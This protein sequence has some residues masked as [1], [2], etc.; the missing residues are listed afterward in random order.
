MRVELQEPEGLALL[1][2]DVASDE[3]GSFARIFCRDDLEAAGLDFLPVQANLSRNPVRHTLRGLHFQAPPHG[4][5]KIVACL[6]GAIWDVAVDL[7]P[8]SP[9]FGQWRGFELAAGG[10]AALHIPAGFAQGFITLAP[11]SELLYLMGAPYRPA[12]GF[13]IRWDDPRL[14]IAWP[15]APAVMSAR[16]AALPGLD[17]ARMRLG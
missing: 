3:R 2:W 7:R 8:G 1:R 12:A 15:A 4:E 10:A 11:D 5:S 14:A 17:E 9:T 13:G 6:R 16:D